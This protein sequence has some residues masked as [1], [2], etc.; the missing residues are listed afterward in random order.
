VVFIATFRITIEEAIPV[1][2]DVMPVHRQHANVDDQT[3][4]RTDEKWDITCIDFEFFLIGVWANKV[5]Q[6]PPVEQSV[7]NHLEN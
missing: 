3:G 1:E 7:A 5:E 6:G 2:F 4:K